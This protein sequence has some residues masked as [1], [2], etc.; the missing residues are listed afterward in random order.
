M[1]GCGAEVPQTAKDNL[2]RAESEDEWAETETE[3]GR[4]LMNYIKT[5]KQRLGDERYQYI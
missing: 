4:L 5:A 3:A 1:P 2:M